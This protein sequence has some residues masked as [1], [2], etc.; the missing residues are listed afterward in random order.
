VRRFFAIN[1]DDEGVEAEVAEHLGAFMGV[2]TNA[3]PFRKYENAR[4]LGAGM[5]P[6]RKS[7]TFKSVVFVFDD[8]RLEHYRLPDCHSERCANF[9]TQTQAEPRQIFGR[10]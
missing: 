2:F 8:A 10:H 1:I 7:L 3:D 6:D 9:P 4:S 5:V